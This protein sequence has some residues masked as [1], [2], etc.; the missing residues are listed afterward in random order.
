MDVDP[1]SPLLLARV[2][3]S[4]RDEQAEITMEESPE[5]RRTGQRSH[6][7]RPW[8]AP[9][10]CRRLQEPLHRPS[11]PQSS[12][13]PTQ[14]VGRAG[15]AT[16]GPSSAPRPPPPTP[17]DLASVFATPAPSQR[18]GG[19]GPG[20]GG[21]LREP[22]TPLSPMSPEDP[23]VICYLSLSDTPPEPPRALPTTRAGAATFAGAGG[24]QE[25][26][27]APDAA[28]LTSGYDVDLPTHVLPCGHRFHACCIRRHAAMGRAERGE[29]ESLCPVCRG[30]F[31]HHATP[32][33]RLD[34][35][36]AVVREPT[37]AGAVADAL[38][39]LEAGALPAGVSPATAA[40]LAET[41]RGAALVVAAV[42][43][44][45]PA[46]GNGDLSP[47]EAVRARAARARAAVALRQAAQA[48]R[49][50]DGRD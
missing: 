21:S 36:V 30:G 39:A 45:G 22:E 46:E 41:P 19:V 11:T 14:E 43:G 1:L 20:L 50:V 13:R 25:H 24:G 15:P 10:R 49:R 38:G 9:W 32:F 48:A 2:K 35:A 6:W 33:R 44:R 8:S 31:A 47:A 17:L 3:S 5:A 7:R 28:P 34:A 18:R 16:A 42:G 40:R 26:P 37:G 12:S 4:E 23:C 27:D 29:T